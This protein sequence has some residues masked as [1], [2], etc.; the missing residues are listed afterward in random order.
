MHLF[1]VIVDA[2]KQDYRT[3]WLQALEKSASLPADVRLDAIFLW[4]STY[5]INNREK[6]S[7]LVRLWLFPPAD[8][9]NDA[10]LPFDELN[11]ELTAEIAAIFEQGMDDGIFQSGL[12]EEMSHA[13]FCVLDG[14][15][16]RVIRYPE[17]D[18]KKALSIIW[19]SFML[20]P[21]Q[22]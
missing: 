15:L 21:Q 19:K 2:V 8:C 13:Y 3:C 20:S 14:Y 9:A 6:L 5:L 4:V 10:L 12:P 11:V 17:L 18:Y 16:V 22:R 1:L 7:F